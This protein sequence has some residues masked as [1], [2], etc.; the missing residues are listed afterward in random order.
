M[1]MSGTAGA[2]HEPS[3]DLPARAW[4]IFDSAA[5]DGLLGLIGAEELVGCAVAA[6]AVGCDS[7]WL[8]SISVLREDDR[9]A[10]LTGLFG[11]FGER[12]IEFP[13][14]DDALKLSGDAVL[15]RMASGGISP[16][17]ASARLWSFADRDADESFPELLH[18]REPAISLSLHDDPDCDFDVDVNEW[19]ANM[20]TFVRGILDRGGLGGTG[21]KLESEGDCDGP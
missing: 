16:E 17:Q 10:I 11:A 8:A 4:R 5:A 21:G 13:L 2:Q 9:G 12:G 1:R 14:K 7:R 20:L 15:A 18:L 19:R 3:E 6:L